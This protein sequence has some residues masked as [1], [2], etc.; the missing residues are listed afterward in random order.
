MSRLRPDAE[1]GP[2]PP[3]RVREI[4]ERCLLDRAAGRP[5][6]DDELLAAHPE[7][8]EELLEELRR[9]RLIQKAQRTADD[10]PSREAAGDDSSSSLGVRCPH[11]YE[12]FKVGASEP[13][14]S[15]GCPSCGESFRLAAGDA[16]ESRERGPT[17]LGPFMLLEKVGEGGFGSVWKARDTRLDR[18]VAVKIPHASRMSR[19]DVELF[20]REA[21]TAAQLR[22]PR[23]VAVHEVGR[24]GEVTYI[25]TDLVEGQSLSARIK[26]QRHSARQAA[27]IAVELARALD[28]AHR[29]GVVHRDLKPANVLLDAEGQPKITDFGLARRQADDVTLTVTGQVLG[30]PAY[31]SPEQAAGGAHQADARSDIYSLG[32]ILFELLTGELPFRGSLRA[33]LDQVLQ[34]EPPTPR[35]FNRHLPRDLETICLKCLE[36]QPARR[37]GSAKALADDLERYLRGEPILARPVSRAE[38]LWR[39]TRRNPVLAALAFL[40]LGLAVVGPL[41][42]VRQTRLAA[43]EHAALGALSRSQRDLRHSVY[44]ARMN[45]VQAAAEDEDFVRAEELLAT[46]V[47]GP[48]EEDQ[49]GF[50]W[51]Y[52]RRVCRHGLDQVI[53]ARRPIHAVAVSPDESLLAF[54]GYEECATLWD[55]RQGRAA[56]YLLGHNEAIKAMAFS[57][58]GK[59]LATGGNDQVVVL[60]DVAKGADVR[61]MAGHELPIRAISFSPLGT[62]LSAGMDGRLLEWDVASGHIAREWPKTCS[63]LCSAGLSPDGTL[64]ATAGGEPLTADP[65]GELRGGEVVL[66]E[67]P[68]GRRRF[69]LQRDDIDPTGLSFAPDGRVLAV[70]GRNGAPIVLDAAS[71]QSVVD[72]EP[73]TT[74]I[75]ATSFSHDGATL[76]GAGKRGLIWGWDLASGRLREKFS[77][78]GGLCLAMCRFPSSDRLATGGLDRSVRLWKLDDPLPMERQVAVT[79]HVAV[80]QHSADGRRWLTSDNAGPEATSAIWHVGGDRIALDRTMSGAAVALHPS[81]GT[82]VLAPEPGCVEWEREGRREPLFTC[83]SGRSMHRGCF[84]PDGGA[85]VLSDFSHSSEAPGEPCQVR[86][87]DWP[88]RTLR[89]SRPANRRRIAQIAFSPDGRRLATAGYDRSVL[90]FDSATGDI[91]HAYYL[92]REV[93]QVISC[94]TFSPD[95]GR[96]AAACNGCIWIWN[97]ATYQEVRRITSN[98]GAIYALAYA[99]DGQTLAVA[100]VAFGQVG[101]VV[102]WDAETWEPK[103]TLAVPQPATLRFSPAGD[104]LVAG[105]FAG[106]L[107]VWRAPAPTR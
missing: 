64:L 24:D 36:K 51:H 13:L 49:R 99:P 12:L 47:P 23:I 38:R 18:L 101:R 91:L 94:V 63:V 3:P 30:T 52:W 11:C 1:P 5:L 105:N 20:L 46:L 79:T 37:Y 32:V 57:A 43:R 15:V 76:Y 16:A 29:Q 7:L 39:W 22:H 56:R 14:T 53:A 107:T 8:R 89:W 98:A 45:M 34:S 78:H 35:K 100:E 90:V 54:G 77:G 4:V 50:E 19:V 42:A 72:C 93:N 75:H 97:A 81:D 71:G 2:A 95:G 9:L 68:S 59:W 85:L 61:R 58:D 83:E 73:Q 40:I 104:R 96:L 27:A 28:H 31:M 41:V 102:L 60:W 103:G 44:V 86:V 80:L 10:E 17:A 82:L 62:L 48:L 6:P 70:G 55:L 87:W 26:Q 65:T 92:E 88:S 84:A 67:Y 33:M 25:V 21:R 74:S 66:W 106:E 69:R